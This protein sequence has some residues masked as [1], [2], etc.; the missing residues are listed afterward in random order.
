ME[1]ITVETELVA[2]MSDTGLCTSQ[3]SCEEGEVT[4]KEPEEVLVLET[5]SSSKE[6]GLENGSSST[7]DLTPRTDDSS[8]YVR[9]TVCMALAVQTGEGPKNNIT[10]TIWYVVKN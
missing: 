5:D 4:D 3:P 9:W 7:E 1:R 6:H 10:A 8:R 2:N